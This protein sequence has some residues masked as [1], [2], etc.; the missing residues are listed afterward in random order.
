MRFL[1]RRVESYIKEQIANLRAFYHK[2]KEEKMPIQTILALILIGLYIGKSFGDHILL[3]AIKRAGTSLEIH[4][5][6]R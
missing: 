3:P 6:E 2:G 1:I 4:K 5:V